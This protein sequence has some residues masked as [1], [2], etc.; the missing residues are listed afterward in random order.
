VDLSEVLRDYCCR[1]AQS[2]RSSTLEVFENL[3][4]GVRAGGFLKDL[5]LGKAQKELDL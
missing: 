1:C 3:V 2:R 5:K 4:Q